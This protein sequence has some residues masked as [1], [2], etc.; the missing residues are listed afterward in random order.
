LKYDRRQNGY[1][2]LIVLVV[3]AIL[4]ILFAT[5]MRSL[6]IPKGIPHAVGVEERPWML[7]DLLAGDGE[8]IKLPR[9]P[10][11][12]LGDGFEL[13]G[14]V[15]RDGD[16]RGAVTVAFGP[17]GRVQANWQTNY[18]AN[19]QLHTITAA[20]RGNVDVKRTFEGTD[21]KDKSR[22]FFIARG[23]YLKKT[24]GRSDEEGTA[25]VLGWLAPDQ[26]ATGA[27]TLTVDRTGSAVYTWTAGTAEN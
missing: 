8:Q 9:S 6:F 19:E 26:S 21:G 13:A 20:M 2:I 16:A 15:Q 1:A 11:P 12:T 5:Q 3:M 24:N 18:T 25:W 10:K 4:L 7:A 27:L 14:T 23:D 17:D 22:L